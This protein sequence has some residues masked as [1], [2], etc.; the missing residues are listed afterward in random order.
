MC[1]AGAAVPRVSLDT[2]LIFKLKTY[3]FFTNGSR[4]SGSAILGREYLSQRG[5]VLLVPCQRPL[6]FKE[7]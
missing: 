2:L 3:K 7:A 4:F 6:S 1:Q 5:Q